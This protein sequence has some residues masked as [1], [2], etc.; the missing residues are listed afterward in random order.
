LASLQRASFPLHCDK[1]AAVIC[2]AAVCAAAAG[3]IYLHNYVYGVAA[4]KQVNCDHANAIN[5]TAAA[6]FATGG[7]VATALVSNFQL[8]LHL[9]RPLQLLHSAA[10]S[11]QALQASAARLQASA[12]VCKCL[13]CQYK[14]ELEVR[15]AGCDVNRF[16]AVIKRP[17]QH[18]L[19]LCNLASY[20]DCVG[21]GHGVY[22]LAVVSCTVYYMFE[23]LCCLAASAV[24]EHADGAGAA[25]H[26]A[27]LRQ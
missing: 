3:G 27:N 23:A 15:Y 21:P 11:L 8:N 4:A 13:L 22:G 7:T 26:G 10:C 18:S 5:L 25:C 16:V 2:S 19:L 12:S 9:Q 17:L 6:F 24:L 1:A 20:T 14:T